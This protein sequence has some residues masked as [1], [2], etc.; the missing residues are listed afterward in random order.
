MDDP[1]F[2]PSSCQRVNLLKPPGPFNRAE[3]LPTMARKWKT[4]VDPITKEKRK[5]IDFWWQKAGAQRILQS[6]ENCTESWTTSAVQKRESLDKSDSRDQASSLFMLDKL[7][8]HLTDGEALRALYTAPRA[9]AS[10]ATINAAAANLVIQQDAE[11]TNLVND[12]ASPVQ[13][14]DRIALAQH[15]ELSPTELNLYKEFVRVHDAA[16]CHFLFDICADRVCRFPNA[17]RVQKLNASTPIY[18]KWADYTT[19]LLEMLRDGSKSNDLLAFF[20]KTRENGLTVPL[21]VSER[22]AERTLL[23]KD[24]VSLPEETWM[25]YVLHFI[26]PE[27]KQH[28]DIPSAKDR[29]THNGGAGYK[30]ADLETAIASADVDSFKRFNRKHCTDPLA[31]RLM[32]IESALKSDEPSSKKVS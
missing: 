23:E 22:R 30:L 25:E 6:L 31:K 20:H 29:K 15:C 4:Y 19:L 11:I 32:A 3:E 10:Q 21:W 24:L 28:L 26:P 2:D 18:L 17:E 12:P 14:S 1:D 27:E 5:L 8:T 16:L 9:S 7:A 13:E